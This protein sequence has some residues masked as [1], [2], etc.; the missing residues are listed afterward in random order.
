L[1][2]MFLC[3]VL[4]L[5]S[6]KRCEEKKEM[7]FKVSF[8][9]VLIILSVLSMV[10]VVPA[11]SWHT[12][13]STDDMLYEEF[14]PRP[15]QLL[16]KI[17]TDYT[18]ELNGLKNQ[19]IDV[20]DWSLDPVDY[21]WFEANDPSHATWSTTFYTEF[22][23]AQFDL[24][25]QV[26]PT[27]LPSFRKALAHVV[28]KQYF[29]DTYLPGQG[30]KIDSALG[31]QP[32]WFNP[33]VADLYNLQPRTTMTPVPDD[34][35]DWEAAYDLLVADLGPPVPDPAHPGD[36][37]FTWPSPFTSPD[38]T[39]T[40]PPVP[41][42]YLLVFARGEMVSQTRAGEFLRNCLETTFPNILEA[43][44]KPRTRVHVMLY[45]AP[46]A[47]CRPQ[48][49]GYYRYHVYTGGWTLSRDPDILQYYQSRMITKPDMYG[50]NYVMYSNPNFDNEVDLMLWANSIGS[51]SNPCDAVYHAWA[52]QEIMENDE[53]CIWIWSTAGY[54]AYLSN[55]RGVVNQAGFG[56][57]SWWTFLN[58]HKIGSESCDTIR[59]GWAGDL[60]DTK[61][62]IFAASSY[63]DY[64]VLD[65]V[66]DYLIKVNPYNVADDRPWMANWE[67]G[68][69]TYQGFSATKLIYHLR[70]DMWWQDVPYKDRT[71]GGG[72]LDTSF[73]NLPVTPVDV[74]FSMEY[75]RDQPNNIW[76]GFY[77]VMCPIL[78]PIIHCGLN[79][80]WK[81][82]WPYDTTL[83][84]W[85]N[86]P[87]GDWQY[88]YVQF[89][90]TLGV[91]DVAFYL[92]VFVPWQ[93]NHWLGGM[94][95]LPMHIWMWIP[96]DGSDTVDCWAEDLVYGSGPWILLDRQP[97]VSMT[98]IPFRNGQSYKGVTLE[99]SGW[100][101]LPVRTQT[102]PQYT[103][104][105]NMN[106]FISGK[107]LM[108]NGS[109]TVQS[110][111][112]SYDRMYQH[113]I[114]YY[115]TFTAELLVEGNV[116]ATQ[117]ETTTPVVTPPL[118]FGVPYTVTK[119][120]TFPADMLKPPD[121][122]WEWCNINIDIRI[123][124][125]LMWHIHS[126]DNPSCNFISLH[127][128]TYLTPNIDVPITIHVHPPDLAGGAPDFPYPYSDCI[129]NVLDAT[130]I[131]FYWLNLV[132]YS[133][134]AEWLDDLHRADINSDGII[135]IEDATPVGFYWLQTWS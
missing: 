64:E 134:P 124:A 28:D 17:Y 81:P 116:I 27:M 15:S 69:Y 74:A 3:I 85:W 94:P 5:Y 23:A 54:K 108:W 7:K 113:D 52:A 42:G 133:N 58:A 50:I 99:K 60:T 47:I 48:V 67:I 114:E 132:Y 2:L 122:A 104:T 56:I 35:A 76:N 90:D 46:K 98:M 135:N 118:A 103:S 129:V 84:P 22:G 95:I 13:C 25:C 4:P 1:T 117:S 29:I 14:G 53:P 16:I 79:S 34:P 101:C 92:D 91:Y 8:A 12:P 19:Q 59:Y 120:V 20:F 72:H 43:L 24:N 83:P 39:Q 18:A 115:W 66:Y 9:L 57:N 82:M 62:N 6:V 106:I 11:S 109:Q 111:F 49:M 65:K 33:A 96:I 89:D 44:G 30:K 68:T 78:S 75:E 128:F 86:Y 127:G 123:S 87:S 102:P 126:C 130:P 77:Q 119:S 55:W 51:S 61:L 31:S 41:D 10:S 45:I 21:Q 97:G 80:H 26:M 71:V 73:T 110:N 105:Q 32:G 93:A 112:V 70:Q 88:D 40:F 107:K 37:M 121:L 38:P 100:M 131:G 36:F 63:W 125:A